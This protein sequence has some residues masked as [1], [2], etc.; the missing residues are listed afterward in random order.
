[1]ILSGREIQKHM[2][3]EIVIEPFDKKRLNPNSYNLSLHNQLLVYENTQ[4]CEAADHPG[5]RPSAGSGQALPGPDPRVHQ[6]RKLCPHVGRT[7][8]RGTAGAVYPRHRRVWG[9]GICRL[10]DIGDLLR[11][12]HPH[13]PWGGDLTDLLPRHPRGLRPVSKRQ[14]SKQYGHPAQLA[15]QGF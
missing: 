10:L 12:A 13:L 4:P 2:G 15:V 5:R 3:K 9:C 14:V 1:M 6:N 11:A 8:F 7:V